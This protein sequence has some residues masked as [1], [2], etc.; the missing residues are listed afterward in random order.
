MGIDLLD[1]KNWVYGSPPYILSEKQR[2][3]TIEEFKLTYQVKE[4]D[5]IRYSYERHTNDKYY[6]ILEFYVSKNIV[7]IDVFDIFL[8]VRHTLYEPSYIKPATTIDKL[9]YS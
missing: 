4:G 1:K 2:M 3:A 8:N 9:L 7:K 5:L 6:E